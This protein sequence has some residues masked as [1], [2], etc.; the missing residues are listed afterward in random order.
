MALTQ[1]YDKGLKFKCTQCGKCCTGE[2]GYVWLEPDDIETLSNHFELSFEE[3]LNT[4]CRVV[5]GRIS[6]LEDSENFDCILLKNNQCTAYNARPKQGKRFPWW[7]HMLES[8]QA[9]DES[10]SYCEGIDH[11]DGKLYSKEQIESLMEE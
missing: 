2:P 5:N 11:P 3:F 8:K 6:L 10:K 4:Y 9:W 1:W 7:N